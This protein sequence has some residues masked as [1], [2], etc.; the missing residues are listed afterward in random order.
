MRL[1]TDTIQ[2]RHV[3]LR[4]VANYVTDKIKTML[5]SKENSSVAGLITYQDFFK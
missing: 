4:K 5:F 3:T 1:S 2:N